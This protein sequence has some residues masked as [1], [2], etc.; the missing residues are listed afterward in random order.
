MGPA[1]VVGNPSASNSGTVSGSFVVGTNIPPGT[2]KVTLTDSST[3]YVAT[4][5]VQVNQLII[6]TLTTGVDSGSGSVSPNCPSGCS[7]TVGSQ[8]QVTA[9]PSS[10][11]QFSSW[12]TQN[13]I[14]CSSDPCTF[15]MPNSAVTLGA[16]FTQIPPSTQTLTT[17]VDSG[18]GDI[19][20]NCPSGCSET[21]GSSVTVTATPSANW[22]FSSW[23]TQSGISCSS[24]PCTFTMPNNA[25]T[26][27][28][29]LR[30]SCLLVLLLLQVR[31]MVVAW[32]IRWLR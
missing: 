4:T 15:T 23:S 28:A 32:L 19:G 20:P 13:G 25:V 31:L 17:G 6:Q 7:E 16:T 27:K 30:F 8:V 26:L 9:T 14:S 29:T 10:G 24:N 21:V 2:R 11:W 1:Y 3:N 22:Q 5:Y 12:S 18:N